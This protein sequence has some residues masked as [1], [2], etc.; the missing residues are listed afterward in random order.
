MTAETLSESDNTVASILLATKR[1]KEKRP[2]FVWEG[3]G[4]GEIHRESVIKNGD[5]K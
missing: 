5:R 4:E 1:R 2:L 3:E